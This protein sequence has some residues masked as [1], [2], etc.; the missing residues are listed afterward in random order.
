MIVGR[1]TPLRRLAQPEDIAAA[2]SY[3]ASEDAKFVTGHSL[4]VNGGMLIS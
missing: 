2:V 3:L 4:N 1:Q